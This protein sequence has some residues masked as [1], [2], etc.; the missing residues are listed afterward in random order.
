MGDFLKNAGIVG[1]HYILDEIAA[2]SEDLDYGYTEDNQQL[3]LDT[4]FCQET[5]WTDLYFRGITTYYRSHSVYQTILDKIKNLLA[6][7][8]LPEWDGKKWKDDIKFINDKLLSN[9]YKSGIASIKDEVDTTE[10]YELL[11]AVKLKESMEPELLRNR[12]VQ[13][14]E[15]LIQ[16]ICAETLIM[17]SAIYNYIN[18]FWDGKC[19][20]LRANAAKNMREVFEND[21][22]EPFRTYIAIDQKKAKEICIDCGAMIDSKTKVSLAFMKDQA[23]DL[24]RKQSAFWNCKVDAFL[25]PVWLSYKIKSD[26]S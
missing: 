15:F 26:K 20:L 21:F 9:S 13:L 14:H 23:D 16:P 8:D 12:L 6:A 18:R 5:D 3:W 24:A 2:A 11:K 4:D 1:M 17:K 19:F 10:A 25:C 7:L 22:S